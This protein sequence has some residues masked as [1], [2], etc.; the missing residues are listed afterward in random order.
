[1]GC[2]I[3][4]AVERQYRGGWVPVNPTPSEE[5][6]SSNHWRADWGCYSPGEN[7]VEQLTQVGKPIA[8][9][10]PRQSHDWYFGR[11]YRAFGQ[12]ANVRMGGGFSEPKG[13]PLDISEQV[14]TRVFLPVVDTECEGA[15]TPA[16]AE[17]WRNT[18]MEND[19]RRY[20]LHPDWHSPSHYT[21]EELHKEIDK[22]G[23]TNIEQRI[24]DLTKEM[25]KVAKTYKLTQAQ[26]R[27]VFWFDN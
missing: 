25:S 27:V 14:W 18:V 21:L 6:S 16:Q 26:V 7:P 4:V 9:I 15:V 8:D 13:V 19:G 1:M 12:L 24:L 17:N 22:R 2:D 10:V 5:P 11:D 23:K 20:I 3:H